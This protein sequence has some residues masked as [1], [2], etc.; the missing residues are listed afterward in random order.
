MFIKRVLCISSAPIISFLFRS[1]SSRVECKKT[2]ALLC[3]YIF[4]LYEIQLHFYHVQHTH[5]PYSDLQLL[6]PFLSQTYMFIFPSLAQRSSSYHQVHKGHHIWQITLSL[7]TTAGKNKKHML[8]S[9]IK[10]PN[11]RTFLFG[12]IQMK[13]TKILSEVKLQHGPKYPSLSCESLQV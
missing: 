13:T 6:L 8:I 9:H 4:Y 3:Q 12:G 2:F 5:I 7:V 1:H 11:I 10:Y